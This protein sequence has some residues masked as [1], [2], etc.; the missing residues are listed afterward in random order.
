MLVDEEPTIFSLQETKLNKPNQI[1]TES[2]KN[3]TIYELLRIKSGGGGLSLGIHKYLQ[4]VWINQGDDEVE[5]LA[6]EVWVNE[7]PIRIVNGYGPQLGDSIERKRKFWEFIET[8]VNNAIVAG[9]G[10]ILQMDGNCHLGEEIIKND[11]NIQNLNGK[12]FCEFLERNPHLTVINSL[13]LCEGTITRMRKTSRGMEKS[14]LDVFVACDK[15]V[16]YVTKMVVDEKREK[17]LTNYR[18]FKQIGRIIES[19]HNPIFLFLSLQFS[20]LKEERITVYQFRNK[21]SQ[22]LFKTLTSNTEDFT[23]CFNND[24]SFEEQTRKWRQVLETFFQ[25]SFK[26]IRITNKQKKTN[27]EINTLMERR[28]TLKKKEVLDDKEEEE[29]NRIEMNIANLCEE[30]NRKKVTENFRS[31]GG[32][33]GDLIHQGI[34]KI[35]KKYFPK[36]KPSLPAGKKNIK[37]QLITN[38]AELKELYLQT[39]KHRLRHRPPQPGFENYLEIQND[40]FKLRLELAKQNKSPPWVMQDLEDA[41][42]DL[43]TGKCRDPEGMIRE[44]FKEEALGEDLKKSLL[45]LFNKIKEEQKFPAFMQLANISAIYK[46]RGDFNDLESDRGIFLVTICRTIIM[47]MIYKEKYPIIDQSMSDSNIGARKKKNIRNH[48]FVVNSVIHDTLSK[49]SNKEIDIMVLDYKQMF[50]SECLFE[51]MNDLYEAGV[52][53]DMFSLIYEANRTNK[54]AVQTPHGLSRREE[55][56]EIVMQGDVLAPL[57][58]SLQVDTFGK[59]CMEEQKHL[60]FYKNKV[61]IGPLGMVDDL[62]TITECGVKTTM[63]NQ[64]INF[65]TG[66]KRLQFGTKKC[67]KMHIGKMK[68]DILCKDLHVGDWKEDVITDPETGKSFKSEHFN[69]Y[70]KMKVKTEQ[71]YLGDL[72]STDGTQTKNVQQRRNKGLGVINQIMQILESTFFGKY[73]FEVAMVLRESL[74]LSSLLL[75]SEAWVSYTE[76]DV[77]ILEQC[78]E[79]LLTRILDCDANTSNALKYLD[80]GILPVRFIIMKRKLAFL[81]YIL[82]EEKNSMIYQVFQATLENPLKNDFVSTCQKYMKNLDINLSFEEIEKMSK[83]SFKKVLKEKTTCAAFK[84]LT[85]QKISQKKI[86]DIK[87][88]KLEMQP[89]LADGDRNTKLS[90]LVFKARGMTL[91]IKLQKR[92]KYD[93]ILCSGCAVNEESGEEIFSC[94]SYGE[95]TENISYSWF[96]R[97]CNKQI[98]AAKLLMKKL[99]IREKIREEVT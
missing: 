83:Y 38:P 43:K 19:D 68:S 41:I 57:I 74:F 99:K 40:L 81:Q 56:K 5:C 98:S 27:S 51:C 34:W 96:Y 13:P 80:L 85:G 71:T 14:V 91:D 65:K 84:Y 77:R 58:S 46:G 11:P 60:F 75:N 55:F 92:W 93:D 95:N 31:V 30:S 37:Q 17:V 29:L 18:K 64:Y 39:F 25:K 62:L 4:P 67:I 3:D 48:I 35:K 8:E 10:F 15:I 76:K 21:E 78:D 73:F 79:I 44:V 89:Y 66:T 52:K 69:G 2:S 36:I 28:R 33:D 88:L 87:Y 45:I 9:A 72:I 94:S 82:K 20:K 59:E 86:S 22:Q 49:K 1:K 6:V 26:K 7:F 50:D 63:M 70:E 53:D 47:K 42:K 97:D 54:V 24:L 12:L 32:N 61:P 23:N 16:P 90:K